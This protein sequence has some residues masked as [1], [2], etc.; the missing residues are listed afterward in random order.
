MAI[1]KH[2]SEIKEMFDGI[3]YEKGGAVLSMLESYVGAEPF[4][5]GVNAYL[6][7]HANGNAT[8][9]DFWSAMTQASGKPVDQIMPTFVLQP[10]VPVLSVGTSCASGK[11]SVDFEQQRFLLAAKSQPSVELWQIPVC[12]KGPNSVA[13]SCAV[14]AEQKKKIELDGCPDWLYANRDAKGYYRVA[15]APDNLKKISAVAE[16]ELNTPERIA[17]VEDA[18]AMSRAGRSP[19]A[20]FMGLTTALRTEH[21]LAVLDLLSGHLD[22]VEGALV[23][24]GKADAYRKFVREQFSALAAEVGWNASAGDSDEKKALRR[25]CWEFWAGPT[26]QRRWRRRGSWCSNISKIPVQ[27]KERSPEKRS[28][29]LV[30]MAMQPFMTKFW[31]DCKNP[32]RLRNTTYA[33]AR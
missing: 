28:S 29:W 13:G 11:E 31:R 18:W 20:D 12:M 27:W 32:N 7:A 24:A 8:A 26:I 1:R 14:V 15:Y 22:Y 9:A 10:G 30:R 4:R 2:P 16:K 21:E 5:K 33:W 3:T 19:I 17:L 6:Q 25:V 23:T